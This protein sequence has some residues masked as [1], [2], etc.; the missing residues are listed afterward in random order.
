MQHTHTFEPEPRAGTI[1]FPNGHPARWVRVAPEAP[2]HAVLRALRLPPHQGLLLLLGGAEGMAPELNERLAQLLG[3][4]VARSAAETGAL[5]LDGGTHSGVMALMGRGVA[6]LGY[7]SPLVGVAPADLVTF[8]GGPPAE[9]DGRAPL[10]EHHTHFVLVET[11]T[12]GGETPTL[13]A[14]ASALADGLPVTVVLVNGGDISRDEVLRAVRQGWPV[15]VIEGSGRLANALALLMSQPLSPVADPVLAEII[16]DG[17]LCRFPLDGPPQDFERLLK[18]ELREDSILKLAWQRFADYDANA[19]RQQRLFQRMQFWILTLGLLGTLAALL[20]TQLARV[21]SGGALTPMLTGGV[22]EDVLQVLVVALAA[23]VTALVAAASRFKSGARWILLRAHAE[24]LK[25]EI[26]R[27]RCL[28]STRGAPGTG[29]ISRERRLASRM[30]SISRQLM[31]TEAN[32]SALRS[33]RGRL[34]PP[35]TLAE[36]DD[37]FSPLT[38]SRYLRVRLNDQLAYY[39]RRIDELDRRSHRLQWLIIVAGGVGTVLG[40]VGLTLWVALTTALVTSVTAWLGT[41]QAEHRLMKYHQSATDLDNIKAWWSA[42]SIEEQ[43][44]RRNFELLRDST[45]LVLQ[46]ELTGWV[47]EMKDALTRLHARHDRNAREA[48]TRQRRH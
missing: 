44:R 47:R 40:A 12:W 45:E 24:A 41:L 16:A 8:P 13:F 36:G 48:R 11:D 19:R 6:D 42:L 46:M 29:R 17:D 32:V 27:Y 4:A 31:Q 22:L 15:V 18:R 34:P 28:L 33:Y 3:Q 21:A 25:R 37:G 43:G 9:A 23:A 14:L 7:R 5:I 10:D 1:H 38:A 35:D 39:R 2:P 26:Y 30:K 20:Q